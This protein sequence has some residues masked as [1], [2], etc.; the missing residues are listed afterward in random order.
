MDMEFVIEY[1]EFFHD[2]CG[3]WHRDSDFSDITLAQQTYNKNVLEM[4]ECE[5]RLF[6]LIIEHEAEIN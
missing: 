2:G 6:L 1:R 3:Q 4:P 5:W